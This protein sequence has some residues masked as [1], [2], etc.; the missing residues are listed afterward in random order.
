MAHEKLKVGRRYQ[1]YDHLSWASIRQS[2]SRY[3]HLFL[4][5]QKK[6]IKARVCSLAGILF[7]FKKKYLQGILGD[8][9][10]MLAACTSSRMTVHALLR[11]ATV[12]ATADG[13]RAQSAGAPHPL[14]WLS[15]RHD[16]RQQRLAG[17]MPQQ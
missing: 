5:L 8:S 9:S 3:Q 10:A 6:N 1:H 2:D 13:S 16:V 7:F 14:P 4:F 15:P 17:I 11:V 12:R